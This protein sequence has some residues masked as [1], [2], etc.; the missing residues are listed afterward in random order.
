LSKELEILNRKLERAL[1]ARKEAEKLLEK[2][3]LELYASNEELK[4]LN[5]KLETL[6]EER[7]EELKSNERYL[8]T[9]NEFATSVLKHNT[10]D[11]IVW[12]VIHI[13]IK[14]LGFEDCVIYLFDEDKKNL[15]QRAAFGA[16]QLDKETV[17]NP[18]IIPLGNGIVGA[19]AK[20]GIPELIYDTSHDPRYILDDQIRYSELAVPIVANG[21]VIGVIDTE[22]TEKNYFNRE[23]LEKLKTI[24]GLV[25]SRMKN[26]ISQEKLLTAQVNLKKLSTAVE[27]SPLSIFITDVDG[28]IEFVNPAYIEISGY[29]A[30]ESIGKKSSIL[31]SGKQNQKFYTNLW[32]TIK[33]GKKWVGEMVNKRKNGELIW[34]INSISPIKDSQGQITNFLA[35]QAEISKQKKLEEELINAKENAEKA[36]KAKSEF[37]ANMSHEIRTPMNAIIGFSEALYHKLDSSHHKKLIRSVLNGGNLLMSLLNDILD[38]SKIEAGM[39]DITVQPTNLK[40][41]I[42]EIKLLYDYQAKNNEIEI[43]IFTSHD[44]PSFLVLDEMR[45][46]QIIFNL[47]GNAIKFTHKGFVN[48]HLQYT[49]CDENKGVLIIKVEDSGIGIPESQKNLIFEVFK[50]S[51]LSIRN[52]GGAGLGLSISQRLVEKMNGKISVISQEGKG[53]V[54]SVEL[55]DVAVSSSSI[56]QTDNSIELKNVV[57]EKADILVVDDINSNIEAIENLLAPLGLNIISANS[58]ESALE[59][60]THAKPELALL[61]IRMPGISGIELARKTKSNPKLRHIPLIAYSASIA[62]WDSLKSNPDFVD[63]LLKPV[64]R[65]RLIS[66]L[67]QFLEYKTLEQKK[68]SSQN[69]SIDTYDLPKN[70]LNDLPVIIKQLDEEITPEWEEVKDQFVLYKIEQFTNKIKNFGKLYQLKIF[71]TYADTLITELESVDLDEIHLALKAYP[72]IVKQFKSFSQK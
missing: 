31:N 24:S 30:E 43:N 49:S 25:S 57:F 3:S 22:H 4:N 60:L 42:E 52:Y 38:L 18:I 58:G 39:L 50:Q 67:A 13:V 14:D 37:L 26:A 66:V 56:E 55:H 41:I 29:S 2:K 6:V 19:V 7:T 65:D 59:I 9:L 21:E 62:A 20:T 27:Q 17:K 36:N 70:I 53:S 23:H 72:G 5:I 63:F 10:I 71:I 68:L 69:W 32:K 40:S 16:K 15:V 33:T 51:E 45:I 28:I 48:I 61:D 1:L 46:K 11:E 35:I 54:F 12:E 8:K 44:F 47:V 34:V 64:K